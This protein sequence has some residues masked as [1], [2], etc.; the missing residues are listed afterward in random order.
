MALTAKQE[1]FAVEYAKHGNASEAYRA[2]YNC[3]K[4]KQATVNRRAHDV[5]HDSN[6]AA[7]VAELRAKVA[8]KHELTLERHLETLDE[9]RKG[10]VE[11]G[12]FGAA[13]QAETA[14]GKVVGLYVEKHEVSGSLTLEQ[15]VTASYGGGK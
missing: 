1:H 12:Q 10:A 6:V 15:L 7:R 14:R 8:K 5:L 11:I 9:L 4:S 13:V 3:A 2:S